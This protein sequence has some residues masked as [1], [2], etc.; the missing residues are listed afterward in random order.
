VTETI[1]DPAWEV[2][3]VVH[4]YPRRL[5]WDT[6]LNAAYLDDGYTEAAKGAPSVCV[7]KWYLGRIT[8]KA[9]YVVF[10]SWAASLRHEDTG[11]DSSLITYAF[12]FAAKP[13]LLRF[14]RD[15]LMG[16]A[17]SSRYGR[18]CGP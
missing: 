6:L 11:D 12:H 15:P 13:E 5:G 17:S 14:V 1:P 10:D 3:D 18:G 7:G 9:V 4:E 8:L 16:G 2:F